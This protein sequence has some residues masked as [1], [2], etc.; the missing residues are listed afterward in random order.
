[1]RWIIAT[2][3]QYRFLVVVVAAGL[4]WLGIA[5]LR[6]MPVDVL[7]EFAPPYIEVQT[8]ALGL[9]ATEV[10]Q[11]IS[12]NV[13]E[14]LSG[15]SW[16]HAVRSRSVPG[17]SSVILTLEPGTNLMRA[18]QLVQ[19][20]LTLAHMLPNVS[21][22]PVILQPLSATSR[23][24]MIS[25]ASGTVSPIEM[26]VLAHWK[27]R[28]ALMGVPG[29]ANVAIWGQ[30]ERQ[31]QVQVDPERLRAQNVTLD[32]VIQTTGNALWVSPLSFLNA[33]TPG[34]GGFIDTPQ[35]RLEVRHILPISSSADLAKVIVEGSKL[36]LG[37]VAKVV[38]NHQPLIGDAVLGQEPGLLF[39]VEKFPGVN[40]LEV[41][42]KVEK[43]LADLRPGLEGIQMESNVF[44]PASFIEMAR[45][46]LSRTL[47][48]SGILIVLVLFAFLYEWR[49][50]LIGA[51]VMVLSLVAALLVLYQRGA[52]FNVMLLAGLM[53]ALVVLIDDAIVDVENIVRR[54]RQSRLRDP[55]TQGTER[56][57]RG[58]QKSAI[59]VVMEAALEMRSTLGF[60][61]AMLIVAALPFFFLPGVSG[62]FFQPLA[63]SYVLALLASMAVALTLTPAL[64]LMLLASAPLRR[65]TALRAWLQRR[66]DGFLTRILQTPGS[67]FVGA[68]AVLVLALIT[69]P[70]FK[71]Q[72][73]LPAFKERQLMVHW[74]SAP[75]TSHPAM[76]HMASKVAQELRQVPGVNKV[77]GHV[78]RAVLAD[79]VVGINSAQLWVSIDP[80]AN[81]NQTVAA[82]QETVE[83]YPGLNLRVRSYIRESLSKA[84]SGSSEAVVVR[85]FGPEFGV[86]RSKA[87]EIRQDLSRIK[88]IVDLRLESPVEQS[89]VAIKVDLAKA[90][91]YGLKPGDVRRSAATL[92]NGLEV[93]S[94]FENQKVFQAV[95]WST[96]ENR[97]SLTSIR[98][99]LID[100]PRGG[101]VRLQEV[102][103]VR[104]APALHTID[105]EAISRRVDV[106][107]NVRGRDLGAVAQEV[108]ERLRTTAFP[109]EYHAVVLGEYAE[110]QAIQQRI[111]IAGL[112]ALLA[113]LFL[114]QAVLQSWR[115]AWLV[116]LGLP[117]ALSGGVL[118]AFL[119][120]GGVFS[121]GL[122][123][124]LLALLAIALRN[125]VLLIAHYRHLEHT[126][127]L[128]FGKEL[129]LRGAKERLVP[130]LMTVAAV[131]LALL[132]FVFFGS[133]PGLELGQPMAL[134]VLGG[135]LTTTLV[136]LWL[137]PALFL[138]FGVEPE[139]EMNLSPVPA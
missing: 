76:T 51:V 44:R 116:L 32:Q 35:Q 128:T 79:Q 20:R 47:L 134:V 97:N 25:M 16:V 105:R 89:A 60:A 18:R 26:G 4:L 28:P 135:L 8:E 54:L 6:T 101:H 23:V 113:V 12:L 19:E 37:D 61:A 74:E 42:R 31:L 7:P 123:V 138:R 38:E 117:V 127:G 73:L 43:V 72:S 88:G 55:S 53:V 69:L 111:W 52:T 77:A 96:P 131:A 103:D 118:M 87:E 104:I 92:I 41:T 45:D 2:S 94:L 114:L 34:T 85:L 139:P 83:G 99:M 59:A 64:S 71:Q 9:S 137:M 10:E 62:L 17:L 86:L 125:N 57:N 58:S 130:T 24:M 68:G 15:L 33:S 22:P 48:I 1:M 49:G 39:V 66:Y 75:G 98:E 95:V 124:G 102:A 56:Q 46:N 21:T 110:R 91:R 36:R 107:F 90:E 70:F 81:Y 112:V 3:L 11:L 126:E 50:A 65:E 5:R 30:R 119:V 109:L 121:L 120:S 106:G 100:T 78:G 115:L 14:L 67:I 40:T 84:L 132:P 108:L 136:G 13:E 27:I 93:G 82:I 129:A 80:K 29:V 133:V 63:L 122:L